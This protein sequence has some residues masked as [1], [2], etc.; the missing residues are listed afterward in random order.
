MGN[1]DKQKE[2]KERKQEEERC[3]NKMRHRKTGRN[4]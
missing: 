4:W 2:K 3:G 1:E